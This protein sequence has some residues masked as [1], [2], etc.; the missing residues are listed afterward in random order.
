MRFTFVDRI[1]EFAPRTRIVAVRAVT[2]GEEY[3]SDHFPTFPI[4]PGVLMLQVMVEAAGWLIQEAEAFQA[5]PLLLS[6]V[7]NI[8]YRNFVKPGSLLRAEVAARRLAKEE[9][10]FEGSGFCESEEVIRGRFGLRLLHPGEGPSGSVP[11]AIAA[12]TRAR[13][14]ALRR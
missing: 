13:F 10:E 3:L 11:A 12:D 7:K 5:G 6:D 9:S 14:E 1:V 4:L 2:L 8:T